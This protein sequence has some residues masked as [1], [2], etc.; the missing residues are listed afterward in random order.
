[1]HLTLAAL[2]AHRTLIDWRDRSVSDRHHAD[3]VVSGVH[4]WPAAGGDPDSRR[5]TDAANHRHHPAA[6]QRRPLQRRPV[7]LYTRVRRR[8][9]QPTGRER[10]RTGRFGHR[11]IGSCVHR[12]LPLPDRLRGAPAPPGQPRGSRRRRRHGH[13]RVRLSGPGDRAT[14]GGAALLQEVRGMPSRAVEHHDTSEIVLAVD[15]PTAEWRWR[16]STTA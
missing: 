5:P 14:A 15:I 6:Q 8:C 10:A 12:R 4:V 16:G 3:T 1:M 13:H 11:G 2:E 9:A 7:R